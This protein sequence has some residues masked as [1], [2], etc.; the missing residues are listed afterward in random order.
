MVF[1]FS[2]LHS[3]LLFFIAHVVDTQREESSRCYMRRAE[4]N[5]AECLY[6]VFIGLYHLCDKR[7]DRM[8]F[9]RP[10]EI[11]VPLE[12]LDTQGYRDQDR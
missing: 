3:L 10:S 1:E 8:D 4:M 12:K 5:K 11:L 9:V 6:K 2:I 7:S